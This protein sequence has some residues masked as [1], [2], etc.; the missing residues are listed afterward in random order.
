MQEPA[1][2]PMA[3]GPLL[4][5]GQREVF[6]YERPN[7]SARKAGYLRAGARVGRTATREPKGDERCAGGF[8]RIAPFGYVCAGGAT[9]LSGDNAVSRL[10]T[11]RADRS[12][13]L[14]YVYARSRLP[15]PLYVKVPSAV[16]QR[17][18]EPERLAQSAFPN[19]TLSPVPELLR[20]GGRVP[21]PFGFNY[22]R[23]KVSLGRAVAKSTFAL[24]SVFEQGARRYGLTTN[25]L[26]VPLDHLETVTPSAFHGLALG[27]VTLPVGFVMSRGATLYAGA[28]GQLRAARALGFREAVPLSGQSQRASGRLY[29][30]TTAGDWVD[31]HRL[32]RVDA[33]RTLP[34][35]AAQGKS[36]LHVSITRQALI[37]FDGAR[38]VYVTL[39]STGADGLGDP[40]TTHSTLQ[41][42][43]LIHTKHVTATMDSDEVGD[44]FSLEDV[45]YVQYFRDNYALHAA[46]WH[47]GFGTARSHGCINLSPLDARWLFHWTE[48][49]VPQA[50]HGAF[51]LRDGT[52]IDIGP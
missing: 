49:A 5:A 16:E 20:D 19:V 38:P 47:D 17:E 3:S 52:L 48:P 9:L 45:P 42:Q 34:A 25:L 39:V 18:L 10:A 33:P 23:D 6:V 46:Y 14:P 12:A 31:D 30:Q 37:A 28:P 24:L 4:V 22:E 11:L 50:F 40:A 41:G 51:S 2:E 13:G 8:Y 32:V 29:W 27:E 26:L 36:W 35:A 1:A 44:E 21:T 43:F 7:F 15:P